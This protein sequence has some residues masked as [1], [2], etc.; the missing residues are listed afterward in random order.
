V[1]NQASRRFKH[2]VAVTGITEIYL[3]PFIKSW[4][5]LDDGSVFI[6]RIN[7]QIE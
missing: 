2:A 5:K 7:K 6:P 1:H 3:P 4:R